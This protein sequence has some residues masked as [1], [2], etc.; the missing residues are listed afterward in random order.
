MQSSIYKT[1][2]FHSQKQ[3]LLEPDSQSAVWKV[4]TNQPVLFHSLQWPRLSSAGGAR[5]DFCHW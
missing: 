1:V 4:A 2:S 3:K 5:D